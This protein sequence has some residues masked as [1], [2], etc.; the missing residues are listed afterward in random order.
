MAKYTFS[1]ESDDLAE[2]ID[3]LGRSSP[4]GYLKPEEAEPAPLAEKKPKG[5]P[6]KVEEPA[7]G[8]TAA[9]V[10]TTAPEE[11]AETPP[12]SDGPE[13]GRAHV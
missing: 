13:I 9:P 4:D 10:P 12:A 7:S 8:A 2:I 3:F 11:P 1:M 6:R 5:R